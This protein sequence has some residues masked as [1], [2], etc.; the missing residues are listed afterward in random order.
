MIRIYPKIQKTV[1]LLLLMG[2]VTTTILAQVALGYNFV[3]ASSAYTPITGGTRLGAN[4][5]MIDDQAFG[6]L[7]IGFPFVFDG[8]TYTQFGLNANGVIKMGAATPSGIITTPLSSSSST[9]NNCVA[10]L[11]G[12]L[13]C[14]ATG[15]IDYETIGTAP[16]RICVVQWTNFY[17]FG[18]PA[19]NLN[20][21]IRL[22][23]TSNNIEVVYGTMATSSTVNF[24]LQ[25]GLR[26]NSAADF[27]ARTT[28]TNWGATT[29]SLANTDFCV[30]NNLVTPVFG[31]TFR[32]EPCTGTNCFSYPVISGKVYI[33]YNGNGL[34]D[35]SDIVLPNRIIST[36]TGYLTATNALGNY[37][38]LADSSTSLTLT[39]PANSPHFTVQA[40][41]ATITT[42][43]Q[44]MQTYPNID[45]R[46]VPND[47]INDL[48][49]NVHT[50]RTRP[51]FP[52]TITLTYSNIG[53]TVLSGTVQLNMNSGSNQT[54]Q[55]ASASQ[56]FASQS[57]NATSWTF[58]G[59]QPFESR[60]INILAN[61]PVTAAINSYVYNQAIGSINAAEIFL[62]NNTS[63]DSITIRASF[64]PNDKKL[65]GENEIQNVSFS[66]V[67]NA[68]EIIYTINFQNVGNDEATFVK[69]CDTLSNNLSAA[70]LRTIAVSH[71]N[72]HLIVE[73]DKTRT[74]HRTVV[75]WFFD[76]INLDYA[77]HNEPASHGFVNFAIPLNPNHPEGSTTYNNANITFDYNQAIFTNNTQVSIIITETKDIAANAEFTLMPNPTSGFLFC[78][79]TEAIAK[80]PVT[81]EIYSALGQ[82]VQR[83]TLNAATTEFDLSELPSGIYSFTVHSINGVSSRLFMKK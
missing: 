35:N 73:T 45:F 54:L 75:T 30:F 49:V 38:L 56:P 4:I 68:K 77:A 65:N 60:Q 25:V 11:G 27:N 23:E 69:V 8:N 33:D 13:Q 15:R 72:Y 20:F 63:N 31:L 62:A 79:L 3:P 47:E 2:G 51:G 44:N 42:T 81:V 18:Q 34:I 40:A 61:V 10:A 59:L 67:Q 29:R 12:D 71:P 53:T 57:G 7:N 64:D 52:T 70:A 19:H 17:R 80:T 24:N 22:Y 5:S 50:G 26:G 41:P 36:N 55:F 37:H 43:G 28:S 83:K 1:L 48:A 74:P 58:T 6:T 66:D 82:L 21:Q 9:T 39:T 16:N 32:W 14:G 76:N 78:N 46:L